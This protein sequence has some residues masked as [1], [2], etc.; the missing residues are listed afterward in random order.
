MKNNFI[1]IIS[2]FF[3][4][5]F[6]SKAHGVEQFNFDVTEVEILE[7]G[8]KFI[9]TKR[10]TITTDDNII[11]DAD[12]FEYD[13]KLNIL[14]ASGNVKINDNINKQIINTDKIVYKKNENVIFT[15]GNSEAVSLSD[16]I[17][18]FAHYFE[19]KRI[20]NILIAKKDVLIENK[21]ENY[22]IIS[23]FIK[24]FKNEEV[25]VTKGNTSATIHSKYTFKSKDVFFQ[26]NLMELSSENKTIL[27]DKVNLYNLNKF[28]YLIEKKTLRGE[29]IIINSNYKLPKSDKFYFSSA[30]IDLE[31]NNFLAKDTEIKIH[32]DVFDNTDNDPRIKGV[33]SNKKGDITVINKGVFTSCKLDDNCPPWAIEAKKIKHDMGK[34][35][36][37]YSNAILKLYEIPILYFPKFFHPDPTVKRQSGILKPV[38]N[39][40]N[41]LGSSFT[42]PYYH[43]ISDNSDITITPTLFDKNI[44]M[45]QNEYRKIGK[46]FNFLGNFGHTRDY[47][48]KNLNKKKNIS[49]LFSALDLDLDFEKYNSSKLY[50]SLEKITNDTF[51]KIFDTNL[52]ENSTSLKPGS[53]T[54]LKSQLKLVLNHEKYNLTTGFESFENLQIE[55]NSDRYQYILPYYDFYKNLFQDFEKGSIILNSNGNNN[56]S[57][58]NQLKSRIVNNL[59]FSSLD[60]ILNNGIKNNF[61]INL[62]NLNSIGKNVT[63][64]KSSPQ[65]EVSSIFEF[66]SSIPMMKQNKN[67]SDY[68]T[69]KLSFRVNPSDMKNYSGSNRTINTGN[70][71]SIDRLGL[72][73]TFETGKS[74]TLGVDYKK[75][76]LKNVNKY[77]E[78][79]LATVFRDKEED[80]I[81][82]KTTLNKKNSN[83]FGSI[84]NNFS[85]NLNLNYNFAIDNDLSRLEYND[86][87]TTIKINNF[88]TSFNYFKELGEMGDSNYIQNSTSFEIN[89]NNY[90]TF[91]TRRNKKINLTEFYDLVYEYK[92]D[93]LIAGIKYKKTYYEDRDLKPSEDLLFTIT[94]FPLT[95]Y[96]QKIDR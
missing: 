4:L 93:C 29:N 8:N 68:L 13:K 44:K 49:Y 39:D 55:K 52:L 50:F 63:E 84:S 26:K 38:L 35:Q 31:N 81:P 78:M 72:S 37:I 45:I 32:K 43:V 40:S 2:L 11:I 33:S 80:F 74:I 6:F 65:V 67:Y 89:E 46:N 69:P 24:Y 71:F 51:L 1:K 73:D 86:I 56:L 30:I 10:G 59:S 16:N 48:S 53:S 27:T 75:E 96:E 77:F 61:Q 9:G 14:N 92:N 90:F 22:I 57:N 20:E 85:E 94:L 41:I 18:I 82:T 17:E 3:F 87:N 91:N 54:N 60:Y 21:V 62:K 25:I 28:K 34:K 12:Q 58:T 64:Y 66:E 88:V 47:F 36:L 79:S 76:K 19:Y 23:D 95:T 5:L 15:E 83:I 42:L 70:I 7:N